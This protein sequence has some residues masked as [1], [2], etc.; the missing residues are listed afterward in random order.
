[1]YLI[2]IAS[3]FK[4]GIFYYTVVYRVHRLRQYTDNF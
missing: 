3:D 1:M 2:M 4:Q